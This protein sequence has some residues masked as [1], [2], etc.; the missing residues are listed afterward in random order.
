MV[1]CVTSKSLLL[2]DQSTSTSPEKQKY[3]ELYLIC[4]EIFSIM[5]STLW[6][7]QLLKVIIDFECTKREKTC[8]IFRKEKLSTYSAVNLIHLKI[9]TGPAIR[10]TIFDATILFL[11]LLYT[12]WYHH[13]NTDPQPPRYKFRQALICSESGTLKL[14]IPNSSL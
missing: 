4:M 3:N 10:W 5:C 13:H 12:I 14:L 11:L 9:S 1:L 2:M 6:L 7:L 8:S